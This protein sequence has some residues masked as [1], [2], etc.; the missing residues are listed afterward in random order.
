VVEVDTNFLHQSISTNDLPGPSKFQF[1]RE[2]LSPLVDV[3][4]TAE[5]LPN[6]D[7]NGDGYLLGN[8]WYF[9]TQFPARR[10]TR[11][12]HRIRRDGAD[13]IIIAAYARGGWR[14]I[15]NGDTMGKWNGELQILD[16]AR[17]FSYET[18]QTRISGAALNRRLLEERIGDLSQLQNPIS[19]SQSLL[20]KDYLGVLGKRLAK[21]P[22]EA[23][24]EVEAATY[25]LVAACLRPSRNSLEQARP[26]LE[27]TILLRVK[28]YIRDHLEERSLGSDMICRDMGIS[29]RTL[30]RLFEPLGGV[31]R[32]VKN[33]RLERIHDILLIGQ[34]SKPITDLASQFHFETKEEFWRAFRRR[35]GMTPGDVR[36]GLATKTSLVATAKTNETNPMLPWIVH[37][38]K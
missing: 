14:E 17:P 13:F 34:T 37:L 24:R 1:L 22:L 32:F 25:D 21:L 15:G 30:Y 26:I 19:R 11:T 29:R 18:T 7:A 27:T 4:R 8:L 12:P 10:C 20:L 28:R 35:F 16:C 36:D 5:D 2:H 3:E 9:R 38:S 6:D 23:G 33:A 31:H